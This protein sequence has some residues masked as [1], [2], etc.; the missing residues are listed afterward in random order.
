MG[1][2]IA[3]GRAA[4]DLLSSYLQVCP[5][6]ARARCVE[7]LGWHG[8]IYV[9]PAE[10]IG[11]GD[12]IVVFQNAH[13]LEPAF[14]VA[15]TAEDWRDSVAALA[16][17]NTRLVFSLSV[18]FSGPLLD[19]A[20]EDSGGFHL[21]GS[22]SCGKTTSL[23]AAS[24]VWGSPSAYP[25]TWRATSNG[26]ESLASLHSDGLLILDELSQIDPR[27]AGEAAYLL[28]NGQGKARATRTGAARQ[29]ARW[30]LVFLSSGEESLGALMARVGRKA[31]AGQEIRLADIE[32]DAG[33]GMGAFEALHDQPSPAAFALA[34]K[35]ARAATTA[36]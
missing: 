36:P 32:A 3:P 26:L 21:R 25:R 14:S 31:S 16:M 5:V 33:A 9:T 2:S 15:G 11:Q 23:K 35:D 13:A 7:R 1:L 4:R 12:E 22:S 28:A 27:E 34:V 29:S 6:D 18:A 30:R 10:P 8:P 19:V 17:G 20:G 24:S